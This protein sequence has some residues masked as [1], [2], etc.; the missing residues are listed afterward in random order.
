[1]EGRAAGALPWPCLTWKMVLVSKRGAE[2]PFRRV[3]P[4]QTNGALRTRRESI[5]TDRWMSCSQS[6][7]S[8]G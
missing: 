7:M 4:A 1:M 5:L 3:Q 2:L 8:L 6:F